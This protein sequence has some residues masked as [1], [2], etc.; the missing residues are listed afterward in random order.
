M[1][2]LGERRPLLYYITDRKALPAPIHSRS[3]GPE[4]GLAADP[5]PVI[6]AAIRAGIDLIQ[7]RERDLA[8][9][10]LLSLVERAVALAANTATRIL[11]NDRLDVAQVAGVGLHLPAHSF[12]VAAVRAKAG[13]D[14]LLGASTHNL[15]ELRAAERGRADFSVFGPI[16]ETASK[17]GYPEAS[18]PLGLAKLAEAVRAVRIPV[19]ALGGITL[20]NAADCLRAGAAGVAAISLF[21]TSA[22]IAATV[23]E[24]RNQKS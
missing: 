4:S 24:L 7:I 21:Q 14:L 23:R 20:A 6:A 5:L 3:A 12:P 9:R 15:D 13:R 18:G 22:D 10:D 8:A 19:L 16:F 2:R 11:V 17:R 1:G